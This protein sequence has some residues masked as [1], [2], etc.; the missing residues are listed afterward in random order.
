ML[1]IPGAT[2]SAYSFKR[3]T[4]HLAA[5]YT[6]VTYDRRGFS[7]S[8]LEGPQDYDRRLETDVDDARRLAEHVG[9]EPVILFGNSS[10][11]IIALE[12]LT[13][14]P[15]VVRT[16]A[17]SSPMI[18]PRAMNSRQSAESM[19]LSRNCLLHPTLSAFTVR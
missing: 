6:V 7:L 9:D 17:A 18:R 15:G 13:F 3:L 5:H 10:G 1:L 8:E 2:G 19:C 4:E 16:V 11:A 14:H 12:V